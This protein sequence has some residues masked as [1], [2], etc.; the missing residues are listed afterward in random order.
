MADP[1]PT[2]PVPPK[3]SAGQR[4]EIN[5]A[6]LDEISGTEK[7]AAATEPVW[8]VT[9]EKLREAVRRLV[10]AAHPRR[11]IL[12]GSRARGEAHEDSDVDL[13]IVLAEVKDRVAEMVRLTRVLRGL[14]LP[15]ELLV[16]SQAMFDDWSDLP[17]TVYYDARREGQTLYD[18]A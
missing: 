10:D 14:I 6:W 5:P 13:L 7:L 18:A 12:F 9:P 1:N 16:V 15:A 8:A 17:G 4:G 2:P 11:I 3:K